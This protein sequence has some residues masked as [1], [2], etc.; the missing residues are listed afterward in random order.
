M[1]GMGLRAGEKACPRPSFPAGWQGAAPLRPH[2]HQEEEGCRPRPERN[3]RMWHQ[4]AGADGAAPAGHAGHSR[5]G[6]RVFKRLGQED[7][8]CPGPPGGTGARLGFRLGEL[9]LTNWAAG[10][11]GR[12][13]GAGWPEK[14]GVPRG[15]RCAIPAGGGAIPVG[16]CPALGEPF[17]S[18]ICQLLHPVPDVAAREVLVP[19]DHLDPLERRARRRDHHQL[20]QLARREAEQGG[21]SREHRHGLRPLGRRGAPNLQHEIAEPIRRLGSPTA[22]ATRGA[23]K[24]AAGGASRTAFAST[25]AGALLCGVP[26]GCLGRTHGADLDKAA[27]RDAELVQQLLREEQLLLRL[28]GSMERKCGY[29]RPPRRHRPRD[30]KKTPRHFGRE[31]LTDHCSLGDGGR[32]APLRV[33]GAGRGAPWHI[34]GGEAHFCVPRARHCGH[35]DEHAFSGPR[36]RPANCAGARPAGKDR[37]GEAQGIFGVR[38]QHARS[39]GGAGDVDVVGDEQPVPGTPTWDKASHRGQAPSPRSVETEM[40]AANGSRSGPSLQLMREGMA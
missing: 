5:A 12:E 27:A 2:L 7:V 36:P 16:S 38:E 40:T 23:S 37:C 35:G 15:R 8:G 25:T 24:R 1:E 29:A 30:N 11:H 17:H 14:R 28:V 6:T 22:A 18:L 21:G 39:P 3:A 4:Y 9:T 10:G 31:R 34:A 32:H 13:P 26:A 20:D 19:E 33:G